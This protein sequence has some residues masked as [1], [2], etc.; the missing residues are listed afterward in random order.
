MGR[1]A[2]ILDV[3][4]SYNGICEALRTG[5]GFMGTIEFFP[6]EGK[7]HYDGH[8]NCGVCF[9]PD[10][11]IS[12]NYLC[13]VCGKRLT[14]GVMHRVEKLADRKHGFRPPNAPGYCSAVP[15]PEILSEAMKV[16]VS[17]KAVNGEYFKLLAKLGNEFHI[18]LDAPLGAVEEATG[19]P[20]IREAVGRMRTGNLHIAPGY[21]GEYGKVKIFKE[22]ERSE[23]KGQM[24][25]L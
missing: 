5:K 13:P 10:E 3:D 7:Y 23:L 21:D 2:N 8:R 15:L 11:T 20:V 4:M 19:S 16:G 14:V 9:A 25:L 1:E 12:R 18:L 22:A 24:S 17:S 6:E